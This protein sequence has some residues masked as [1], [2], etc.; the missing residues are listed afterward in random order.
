V[1]AVRSVLAEVGADTVP[2][3]DVFNKCDQLDRVERA[4]IRVLHPGALSVSAITGEGR[5]DLV[6]MMEGR[7]ALDTAHVTMEFDTGE[8]DRERIAQLYRVGRVLRHVSTDGRV[9]IEAEVPRRI[10]DRF[11]SAVVQ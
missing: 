7:L 9:S 8:A 1:A 11:P 10:L 6:A 3:V 4:R 2:S 5:D